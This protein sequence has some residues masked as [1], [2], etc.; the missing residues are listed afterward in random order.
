MREVD[1]Y[2]IPFCKLSTGVRP[3]GNS[4][5]DYGAL[6]DTPTVLPGALAS[7]RSED[8][9]NPCG[10]SR[11]GNLGTAVGGLPMISEIV[12]SKANID[13]GTRTRFADMWHGI[14]LLFCVALIPIPEQ[15]P[16]RDV[17]YRWHVCRHRAPSLRYDILSMN[18]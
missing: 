16:P 5:R 15:N 13:N 11:N 10:R 2:S 9:S 7:N 8:R 6:R 3:G 18:S 12:R 14:F 4:R 1:T 17:L